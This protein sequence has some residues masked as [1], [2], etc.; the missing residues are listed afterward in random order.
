MEA[1]T[2]VSR[3]RPDRLDILHTPHKFHSRIL[4]FSSPCLTLTALGPFHAL[5]KTCANLI[6]DLVPK[7]VH[8]IMEFIDEVFF[9]IISMIALA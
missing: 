5:G 3:G 2:E 4:A 7:Y 8:C 1:G 9:E 6:Y